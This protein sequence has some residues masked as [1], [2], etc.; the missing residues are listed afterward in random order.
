MVMTASSLPSRLL[1]LCDALWGGG[2]KE[3][4]REMVYMGGSL[5]IIL[6]KLTF[7]REQV[8]QRGALVS[9]GDR[10]CQAFLE[11]CEG[12]G[13][14]PDDPGVAWRPD[15]V[16]WVD[17]SSLREPLRWQRQLQKEGESNAQFF[18]WQSSYGCVYP[19]LQVAR[20]F[21]RYN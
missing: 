19:L 5:N 12:L 2:L 14:S 11:P 4:E 13:A 8:S 9:A 15:E 17:P 16:A 20:G 3:R 1:T 18:Y 7:S 6:L 10:V 21:V